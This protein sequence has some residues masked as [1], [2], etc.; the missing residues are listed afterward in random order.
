MNKTDIEIVSQI[1]SEIR[2][3]YN[4]YRLAE[5][6][7]VLH[8]F[9]YMMRYSLLKTYAGKYRTIVS[10]I[11]GRYMRGGVF[12]AP[13]STKGGPKVCEFYHDGFKKQDYGYDNVQDTLPQFMRYDGRN[14]LAN[15]LRAGVCEMCG[16][17]TE[18]ICM[19]HVRS[20]K[21]LTG[22][23]ESERLMMEMRRKSLALCPDCFANTHAN[24]SR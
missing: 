22:K 3:I 24:P 12:R 9:Y 6:V 13:Y 5:N 19:H 14:T 1:N 4:F 20:L 16:G 8:K 10:K 2:G 18:D 15:R 7:G 21:K 17:R 11:K 23:T